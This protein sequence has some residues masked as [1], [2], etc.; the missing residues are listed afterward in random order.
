M[1]S[2]IEERLRYLASKPGWFAPAGQILDRTRAIEGIRLSCQGQV[3]ELENCSGKRIDQLAILLPDSGPIAEAPRIVVDSIG[4]SETLSLDLR[5][6]S[7]AERREQE[8]GNG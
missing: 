5:T 1:R 7:L 6:G 8:K 3:L 2:D 4:P